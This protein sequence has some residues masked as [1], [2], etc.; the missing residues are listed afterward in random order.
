MG[1]RASPVKDPC[2]H[3]APLQIEPSDLRKRHPHVLVLAYHVP[4]RRRDL[5]GRKQA[6]CHLI[7]QGLEQWWL[8]R[9]IRVTSTGLRPSHLAA[10]SP[11]NP[12][13]TITTR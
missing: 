5:T 13:P 6:R 12:P 10:G 11:P 3:D 7:Q 1:P 9:S 8:R 4:D 2:V